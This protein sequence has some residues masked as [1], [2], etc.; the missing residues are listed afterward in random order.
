MEFVNKTK[1]SL[2]LKQRAVAMVAEAVGEQGSRKAAM[3][4]VANLLGYR[5]AR[6]RL[7]FIR[8]WSLAVGVVQR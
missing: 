1:Y 4:H 8:G 3:T 5:L 6:L 7:G 2:E